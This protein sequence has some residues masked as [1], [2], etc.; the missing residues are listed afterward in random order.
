MARHDSRAQRDAVVHEFTNR[1]VARYIKSAAAEIGRQYEALYERLVDFGAHPN[2][3]GFSL[4]SAISK[5]DGSVRFDTIYLHGDG[6][7]LD[8]GLRTTA[9]AGLWVLHIAQL[10]YPAR[11]QLLG[12]R[13]GME[14]IRKRY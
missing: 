7:P 1:K 6:T 8:L 13:P 14:E 11:F 4:S 3:R 12:I 5:S 10:I 2:E 9:Q